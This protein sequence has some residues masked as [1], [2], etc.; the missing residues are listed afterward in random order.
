[1][2][3]S[4]VAAG[5]NASAT[6]SP[7]TPDWPAGIAA[8]DY[9]ICVAACKY[10]TASI[11]TP[12]GFTALGNTSG[13]AGSDGTSEQGQVRVYAF[14][15]VADGSE[16]GTFN[17]SWA[18]DGTLSVLWARTA[19]FRNATGLWLAAGNAL[20]ADNSPGTSVSFTYDTD[21]GI[22]A[23]DWAVTCWAVNSQA[24][25]VSSHALSAS[26][27]SGITSASRINTAVA[28]GAR[29][30]GGLATHAIGSGTASG[31]ATY[32]HTQSSSNATAP[33]GASVLVRL[34]ENSAGGTVIP[35]FMHNYRQRRSA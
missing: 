2:A 9:V 22:T 15:K 11:N 16:S 13:G 32:T 30:R 14:G 5:T 20:G 19:L 34:R 26:G 27:L 3:I 17:V 33:A 25:T 31:V 29:L 10:A 1:M 8:G 35:L 21:P 12:S 24:Y 18:V 6:T 4:F 7:V 28:S 23:D